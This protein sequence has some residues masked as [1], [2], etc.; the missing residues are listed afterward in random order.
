MK[1]ATNHIQKRYPTLDKKLRNKT[2]YILLTLGILSLI[3]IYYNDKYALTET[4]FDPI[5]LKY[6]KWFFAIGIL[7]VGIYFFNKNL[8]K[9]ITKIMFGAFGICLAL[10][11]FLFIQ[12]YESVQ[13][14]KR[15]AE[16]YELETCEKMEKRFE[17]DLQN[18]EVKY[19]QFGIGYDVKLE[20]ILEKKY[21]IE[22]F[23]MGCMIQSEMECYNELV[24]EYLKEKHK[25]TL[26]DIYKEIE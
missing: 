24:N 25:K 23:G 3:L 9:I 19:F 1:H 17:T 14:Q 22:M 4:S 20:Q 7:S 6:S 10:N 13:L 21:D 11:L 18:S 12:I 16:Y 8:K 2:K 5:E 26:V 15:Y